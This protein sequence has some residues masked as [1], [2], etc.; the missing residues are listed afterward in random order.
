MIITQEEYDQLY[1]EVRQDVMKDIKREQT[2][3]PYKEEYACLM[4][5]IESRLHQYTDS[6]YRV[7]HH[8][9]GVYAVA[10]LAL[11]IT[12]FDTLKRTGT[13]EAEYFVEE[14]FDLIDRYR[15]SNGAEYEE[16]RI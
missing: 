2:L 12:R 10:K 8:K 6:T 11:G 15:F 4:K 1:N 5:D 16:S 13:E 7:H 3:A 14:I 9:A